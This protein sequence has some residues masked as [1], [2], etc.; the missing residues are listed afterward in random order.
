MVDRLDDRGKPRYPESDDKWNRVC[1][2]S[3]NFEK[4]NFVRGLGL[5]G[6]VLWPVCPWVKC[7]FPWNVLGLPGKF[8]EWGPYVMVVLVVP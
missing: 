6:V 8:L 1:M 3:S 5:G 2:S 7:E 4:S